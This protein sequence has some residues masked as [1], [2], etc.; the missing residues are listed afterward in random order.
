MPDAT[1]PGAQPS[2]RIGRPFPYRQLS[3]GISP[4]H[5]SWHERNAYDAY[6][7]ATPERICRAFAISS[8]PGD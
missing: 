4:P 1:D 3:P 8:S 7:A 2:T 5:P 6:T